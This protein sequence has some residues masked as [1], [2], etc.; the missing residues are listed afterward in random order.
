M[1]YV[2]LHYPVLTAWTELRS[3][4]VPERGL[5]YSG[6]LSWGQEACTLWQSLP[7]MSLLQLHFSHLWNKM[8]AIG[9]CHPPPKSP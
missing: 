9:H 8:G 2:T 4:M 3:L 6:L 1:Q 7:A 5:G